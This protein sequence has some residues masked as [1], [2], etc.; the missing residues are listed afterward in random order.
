MAPMVDLVTGPPI[1]RVPFELAV[2]GHYVY[3]VEAACLVKDKFNVDKI[4]RSLLG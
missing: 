4:I 3:L 2:P 1:R